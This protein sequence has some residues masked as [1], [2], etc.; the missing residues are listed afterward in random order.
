MRMAAKAERRPSKEAH[1]TAC[2]A[3]GG[4]LQ[5]G[6]TAEIP[7]SCW[8][9]F[10]RSTSACVVAT[11]CLIRTLFAWSLPPC[12]VLLTA[13][14]LAQLPERAITI[15]MHVDLRAAA[16]LLLA[17]CALRLE[18]PRPAWLRR[19]AHIEVEEAGDETLAAAQLPKP[20]PPRSSLDAEVLELPEDLLRALIFWEDQA[21]DQNGDEGLLSTRARLRC[22]DCHQTMLRPRSTSSGEHACASCFEKR[23]TS[24]EELQPASKEVTESLAS[25]NLSCAGCQEWEGTFD[26]FCL[27]LHRC[28]AARGAVAFRQYRLAEQAEERARRAERSS[29]AETL[30][31][32]MLGTSPVLLHRFSASSLTEEGHWSTPLFAACSRLWT[33]RTGCVCAGKKDSARYFCLIA[34]GHTDRLLCSIMFAKRPGEGFL[35]R[36]V[37]DWPPDYAGQPWGATLEYETLQTLTQ[38][39]G[40]LLLMVHAIDLCGD[41]LC[42]PRVG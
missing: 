9:C 37:H 31:S 38:A 13:L 33:L 21:V 36:R 3:D 20:P 10:S 34:H 42:S 39:D 12:A 5:S 7:R 26:D 24:A 28:P 32:Q 19:A 16:L 1:P 22:P 14:A 40:S 8:R 41:D 6:E 35:E 27:H 18:V 25:L 15:Q 2:V 11:V 4:K 30:Y 29:A 17:A 23:G